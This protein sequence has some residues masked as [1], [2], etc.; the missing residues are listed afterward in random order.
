[1]AKKSDSPY[2]IIEYRDQKDGGKIVSLKVRKIEDSNLGLGF[3]RISE[4]FFNTDSLVLQPTEVQLQ[5][6]F[7]NVRSLH[8][9]IYSIVSIEEVGPTHSGLKF[10]KSRSNLIAFPGD[11]SSK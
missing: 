2:Y 11:S 10:K 3:V 9:S 6:R 4:F 8:L 1:M 5:E 7:A